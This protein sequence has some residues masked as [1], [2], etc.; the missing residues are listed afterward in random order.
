LAIVVLIDG[1]AAFGT[2]ETV[3]N[4]EYAFSVLIALFSTLY[5]DYGTASNFS[6]TLSRLDA[7]Y[8]AVG[9]LTTAGTGDLVARSDT[10]R[11][12]Q[13]VQMILGLLL[14]VFAVSIVLTALTSRS[15][16]RGTRLARGQKPIQDRD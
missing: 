14:V 6:T 3:M 4:I 5:W 11:V 12:I 2:F 15:T 1:R 9:T 8:F 7:I 13:T 10:A 16:E